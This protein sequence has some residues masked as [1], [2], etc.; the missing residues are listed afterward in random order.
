MALKHG[1][2]TKAAQTS[3]WQRHLPKVYLLLFPLLR[4]R[5]L[6]SFLGRPC[7]CVSRT[8]ASE[9][10]CRQLVRES[11]LP[12]SQGTH[13]ANGYRRLNTHTDP[14]S[15]H[16]QGCVC[17]SRAGQTQGCQSLGVADG[18]VPA[19]YVQIRRTTYMTGD[20]SRL[21]D[22]GLVYLLSSLDK[23]D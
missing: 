16:G 5:R 13:V 21:A 23:S 1:Q 8:G 17:S 15:D 14:Q 19:P 9:K 7:V 20:I 3:T 6:L 18:R 22:S 12:R 4:R 2:T 11:G 10:R